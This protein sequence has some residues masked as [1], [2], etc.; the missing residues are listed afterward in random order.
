MSVDPRV[1]RSRQVVQRAALA[2]LAER[3]LAGLT[4]EGVAARA[5]VARTTVY[6][7][8]PT[9]TALVADALEVLNEQP[10][11]TPDDGAPLERVETLMYH[12]VD[13]LGDSA[14][15]GCLPALVDAASREPDVRR[16]LADY[17]TRRRQALVDALADAVA[18]GELPPTTDPEAAALALS[19]PLFYARLLTG[20]PP[21]R[22]LVPRLLRTVL[23]VG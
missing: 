11:R 20:E 14:L 15:T 22:E 17:T 4:I 1:E 7:H 8:W 2:E 10:A 3:G 9:R 16:F 12:L 6:R 5:R 13:V 18:A 19:G 21:E 23:G